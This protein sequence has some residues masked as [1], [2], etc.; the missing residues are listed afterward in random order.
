MHFG[1]NK[2][3]KAT[4][5][6]AS[7]SLGG[8][9]MPFSQEEARK[10]LKELEKHKLKS[11]PCPYIKDCDFK[12]LP[13]VGKILCLDMETGPNSQAWM[14]HMAKHHMWSQCRKYIERKREEEGILPRDLEAFFKNQ[15]EKE[16]KEE[17]SK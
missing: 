5:K 16:K 11:K 17:K 7:C 9:Q 15:K 3:A 2:K 4:S 8:M 14:A 12:M 10:R 6:C 13:E 1:K